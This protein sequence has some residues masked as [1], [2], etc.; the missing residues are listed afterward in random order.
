VN[1]WDLVDASAE[2]VVGPHVG[3]RDLALLDRLAASESL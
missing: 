1:N 3:A 2:H